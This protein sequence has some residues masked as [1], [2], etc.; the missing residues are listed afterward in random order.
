MASCKIL[1]L[2][3]YLSTYLLVSKIYRKEYAF[4]RSSLDK[5]MIVNKHIQHFM[6]VMYFTGEVINSVIVICINK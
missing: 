5:Y 4:L 2:L 1:V 6:S 3:T